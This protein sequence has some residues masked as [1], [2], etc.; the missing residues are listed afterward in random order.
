MGAMSTAARPDPQI[1]PHEV[2]Q[3]LH[4]PGTFDAGRPDGHAAWWP[5]TLP[6]GRQILQPIRALPDAP[7][8]GVASL[9]VNQAT[10]A[11]VD[12]LTDAMAAAAAPHA[13]EVVVGVPT[14]GLGLAEA[15]A[16]RL[17]HA[18][19]AA[20]GISRKFWYD[21]GLSVPLRS[22]TSPG[23]TSAT[24]PKR[25]WLDPRLLPV[26][27]RRRV[28]LVDDVLSTGQSLASAL[29]LLDMAD[30]RPVAAVFAMFQGDAWRAAALPVAATFATPRLRR[31]DSGRWVAEG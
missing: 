17:G 25:L 14:L 10:F 15:V 1:A 7:D 9:I 29:A 30:V 31:L 5:G 11:V 24:H 27:A 16:R 12:A 21:D 28:L 20:L 19:Y 13:P 26:L 8:R 22:I 4:P 18:R 3:H 2:W 23:T 6:D